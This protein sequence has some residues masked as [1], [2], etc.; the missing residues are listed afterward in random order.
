MVTSA[1][2]ILPFFNKDKKERREDRRKNLNKEEER[3]INVLEAEMAD[4][5]E[6]A[7]KTKLPLALVGSS[8]S[9]LELKGLV[10][11]KGRKF[12]LILK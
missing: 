12:Y 2:D 9:V 7:R 8:L 10:G 11:K 4:T 6:I 5:D 3:I 1:E